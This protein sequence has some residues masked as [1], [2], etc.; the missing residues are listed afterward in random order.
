MAL[1]VPHVFP[2]RLKVFTTRVPAAELI[3]NQLSAAFRPTMSDFL[4]DLDGH[5]TSMTAS[6]NP[7]IRSGFDRGMLLPSRHVRQTILEL[8]PSVLC[9]GLRRQTER[10]V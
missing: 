1:S 8:A 7:D 2:R 6:L 4:K 10:L 5:S 9:A 3:Q